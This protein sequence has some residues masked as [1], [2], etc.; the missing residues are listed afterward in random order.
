[1][2]LSERSGPESQ[3]RGA[4]AANQLFDIVLLSV[5]TTRKRVPVIPLGTRN[6]YEMAE[7]LSSK[8][9]P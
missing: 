3:I 7:K 8:Y 6:L 5:S 1:M 4:L 9:I 2:Q